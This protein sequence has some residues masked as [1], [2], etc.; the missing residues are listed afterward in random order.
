M[1]TPKFIKN[2]Q[3]HLQLIKTAIEKQEAYLFIGAGFSQNAE[4]KSVK[5]EHYSRGK[6]PFSIRK[7]AKFTGLS[8]NSRR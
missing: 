2:H 7:S 1:D 8:A 5:Q 6:P 4:P 3:E